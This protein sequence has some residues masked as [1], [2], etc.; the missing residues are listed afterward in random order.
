V[1]QLD[2]TEITGGL[3]TGRIDL[4]I[5]Y[6]PALAQADRRFLLHERYVVLMRHDHPAARRNAT[7][8]ALGQ[9]DYVVVRSHSATARLL[10]ELGLA[11]RIRLTLPHF[12]VLPRILADTDLAVIMPL[13]LSDAFRLLGRYAVWRTRGLPSFDVSVHWYRRYQQDA[14]NKWLRE[15][16]VDLFGERD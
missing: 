13:R 2:E 15:T 8:H 5:G 3:D 10:R 12:M 4:A 9:L 16:I 14:G 6:I 7:R 11:H 1:F